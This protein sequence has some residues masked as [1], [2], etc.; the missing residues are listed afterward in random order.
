MEFVCE[1]TEKFSSCKMLDMSA[2]KISEE[3]ALYSAKEG[4]IEKVFL[5]KNVSAFS[6]IAWWN[7]YCNRKEL[8]K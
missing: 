7:G 5:W 4:L 6:P 3:C 8:N 1:L 2:S